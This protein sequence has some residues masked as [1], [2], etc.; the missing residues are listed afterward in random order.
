MTEL[1]LSK[2]IGATGDDIMFSSN[3]TPEQEF[4]YAAS[5]NGIINLDDITHIEKVEK[6]VGK[7]PKKMSCR[8]NPA[9][10]LRSVMT[11]WITLATPNT[12]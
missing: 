8:Y 10:S 11:S 2:A 7:L 1:M 6:A 12:V 3:D 9:E 5:L 4:A